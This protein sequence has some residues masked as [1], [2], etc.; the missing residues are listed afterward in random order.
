MKE[1]IKLLNDYK[2][3]DNTIIGIRGAEQ[4]D[5]R[6]MDRKVITFM[7]DKEFLYAFLGLFTGL[8]PLMYIGA[9]SMQV[10]LWT[11]E[12]YHWKVR[13]WGDNWKSHLFFKLLKNV[14]N[15]L[16]GI[17]AEHLRKRGIITIYWVANCKDDF[18]RAI[19]YGAGGIMTD[20]PAE[21]HEYLESL[22]KEEGDKLVSGVSGSRKGLKKD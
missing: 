1:L 12:A 9:K 15:P 21:L 5:L 13:E 22:K 10:P 8:L 2:R 17:I 14:G 7:N 11:E 19:K 6:E 3:K 20:N 18:E 4:K 16:M